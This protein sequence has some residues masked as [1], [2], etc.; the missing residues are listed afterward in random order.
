MSL[1]KLKKELRTFASPAQAKTLAWFFKTG[2]GQYGE[3]DIF[4][5][6][7]NPKMRALAKK[8]SSLNLAD[9]TDLLHSPFHEERQIALF[10]LVSQFQK[11]DAKIQKRIYLFYLKNTRYINNWDL[12]DLSAH[13]IVGQYLLT[14]PKKQN[15]LIKLA[16]SKNLWKKRIAIIS[17][18]AFISQKQFTLTFK[19]A[20]I[21][22]H[23]D[24][25]LIHKAVGWMLREVGNRDQKA[26]ENFLK[27]RYKTM[28]RTMLRYAIEKF[29]EPLRQAYLKSKT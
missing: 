27:T 5:G 2:P 8:Y 4:I 11:G 15:I 21:L 28:P 18:A 20:D 7:N 3:G 19:I 26:E 29:P 13:K 16:R 17:T 23:D 9:I 25:D 22:L 10:I 24:H 14:R 1:I 12:V 6:L